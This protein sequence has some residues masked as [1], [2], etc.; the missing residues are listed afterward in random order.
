MAYFLAHTLLSL[1][2]WQK[3][4]LCHFLQV[5]VINQLSWKAL[6]TPTS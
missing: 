5:Q 6:L 2:T 1:V 4:H 3:A